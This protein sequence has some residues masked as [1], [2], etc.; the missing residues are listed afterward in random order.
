M[1]DYCLKATR[2]WLV[3]VGIRLAVRLSSGH[4]IL[5]VRLD[6]TVTRWRRELL[7][8]KRQP[9]NYIDAPNV[10]IEALGRDGMGGAQLLREERYLVF[11]NHPAQRLDPPLGFA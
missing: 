1:K 7:R 6:G 10:F 4:I 9:S 2:R 8:G 3:E 11:L 5:I